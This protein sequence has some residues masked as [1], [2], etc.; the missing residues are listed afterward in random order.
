MANVEVKLSAA[1]SQKSES[2]SGAEATMRETRTIA[3]PSSTQSEQA[4]FRAGGLEVM[5][6]EADAGI[7]NDSRVSVHDVAAFILQQQGEMT[8]MKLQK[9]VY[10]SQV[11]SLV[12]DEDSLFDEPIE[13]WANGPVVRALYLRHQGRF[14]LKEWQGDPSKLSDTQRETILKVLEFYGSMSSQTLSDLTHSEKPWQRARA[15]LGIG[16][17]G[18]RVISNAA[19]FEYYSSL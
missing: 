14:K 4:I 6:F 17:R 19:M 12:W 1:G 8:A 15:D 13:A 2:V 16:E 5:P 9:L 18:N 11:W 3:G 7:E 10:Y